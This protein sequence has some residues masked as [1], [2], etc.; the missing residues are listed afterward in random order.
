MFNLPRFLSEHKEHT[1]LALIID[2]PFPGC[3][4]QRLQ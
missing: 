2:D 3:L 1:F 4:S